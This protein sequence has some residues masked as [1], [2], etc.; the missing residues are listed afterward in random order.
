[1]KAWASMK[2]FQ[3]K[4]EGPPLDHERRNPP[5]PNTSAEDHLEL[6]RSETDPMSRPTRRNRNAE[7]DFK[8][9]K[10]TNAIHASTTD[11]E[12]RVYRKSPCTGAMLCFMGHALMEN[13]SGLI[14][15]GDLRRPIFT[16]NEVPHWA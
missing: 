15:Q 3:P 12:S 14:V 7:V 10:R 8:R 11:P 9:E 4:A 16:R 6:T 2:S 5:G 1:V 13:R